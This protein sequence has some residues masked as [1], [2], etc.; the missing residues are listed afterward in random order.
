MTEETAQS[1]LRRELGVTGATMM[2]LG[3]IMGAGVFVSLGI[4]AGLAG[5]SALIAVFIAALVAICN[6][7]NSAQLAASHPV[8]GGAYEYG[9][10]YL[11]PWLGFTAGTVFLAAKTA[12]AATSAL[13]F[14]GYLLIAL[15]SDGTLQV[16][17][18]LV[19]V[20][21]LTI[22]VLVGIR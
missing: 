18:A 5:P 14:A 22:I 10:V 19:L 1:A 3:S 13:G 12:S 21:V 8:S 6:G 2:G 16:P 7:L 9:H 17:V 11:R 15:G 20:A 4:V